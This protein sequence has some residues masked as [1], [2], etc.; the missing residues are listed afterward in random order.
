RLHLGDGGDQ[1]ANH[2]G[3]ECV[4]LFRAN[5]PEGGEAARVLFQLYGGEVGHAGSLKVLA[6]DL[7]G[8]APVVSDRRSAA[9]MR[10][11]PKRVVSIGALR[12]AEIARP[13]TSLVCAGSITP[14]SH[15]RALE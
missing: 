14:S 7:A 1:L 15:S 12:L 2:Q 9:Y 10:N 3:I 13:S 11:T 5:E 4:V 6:A 8:R